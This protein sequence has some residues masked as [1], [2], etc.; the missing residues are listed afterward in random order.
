MTWQKGAFS[1]DAWNCRVSQ[2]QW[3]LMAKCSRCAVQRQRTRGHQSSY[4]TKMAW[5]G[6]TSTSTNQH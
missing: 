3:R 4:D 5:Q 2:T 1:G 6:Q